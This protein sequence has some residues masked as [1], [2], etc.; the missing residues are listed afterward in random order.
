MKG[1]LYILQCA[2]GSYYTGSTTNIQLRLWQ[3]QQG[4][5]AKH[6][7]K[8]L[9]VKLV[10]TE[11]FD[12]IDAAFYREKQVQ[13]WSRKKKEALIVGKFNQLPSLSQC[14]NQ[15]HYKNFNSH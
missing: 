8:R 11:E 15:S 2:D 14:Q 3:H 7:A 9:P 5:G 4:E 10:Y 13:G 12:R 1:Y 6:T